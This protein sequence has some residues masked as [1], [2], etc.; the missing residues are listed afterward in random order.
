MNSSP[1]VASSTPWHALLRSPD[2][3]DNLIFAIDLG[4]AKLRSS[5]DIAHNIL[6]GAR[7]R[8]EHLSWASILGA[9]ALPPR[10]PRRVPR[11]RVACAANP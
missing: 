3:S 1:S 5:L 10:L 11:I 9:R 2:H 4:S 7:T 8:V 6:P